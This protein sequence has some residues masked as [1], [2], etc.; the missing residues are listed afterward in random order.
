[1]AQF[2]TP[3]FLQAIGTNGTPYSGAKLYVY[4][5]GTETEI[6]LF[7]DEGLSTP[8]A[9]PI[10]ADAAGVFAL[11]FM[12]ETECK[13][14]LKTSADVTILTRDP[15]Y[16]IGQT[17]S[18]SADLV[19]F[20]GDDIGFAATNVQDA[21][22]EQAQAAATPASTSTAGALKIATTPNIYA[23]ATGNRAVVS[24]HLQSAAVPVELTDAATVAIDWTAGINFT[25]ELTDNRILGN[26]TN[27]IPGQWRTVLVSGDST[28]DR[29]LSFGNQY[30]GTLPTLTDIDDVKWYLLSL[31][32]V[33]ATH[34]LVASKDASAP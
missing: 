27:G 3:G 9:N 18:L 28:T 15:V 5:T 32:C 8:I 33:S 20:D 1:M 12:A 26:P 7:S 29:T 19:T 22:E 10:V 14:V 31:Y 23:A 11:A 16:T 13:L 2:L 34:F 30:G 4:E 6:S 24:E 21:I 17:G 25:I